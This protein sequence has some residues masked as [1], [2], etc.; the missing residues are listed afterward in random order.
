MKRNHQVPVKLSKEELETIER[1][2]VAMGMPISS[3]M[4]FISLKANVEVTE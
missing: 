1:K 3:F 2:A 4:R